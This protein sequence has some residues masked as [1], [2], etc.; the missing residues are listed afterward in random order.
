MLTFDEKLSVITSF[1]ELQRKD[2]SLGRVN[3]QYN[4]SVYDK[5]NVVYHLHPNGNGFVYAGHLSGYDT[6]DKGL[7]NIREFSQEELRT[8]I[9]QSINS[10]SHRPEHEMIEEAVI[11]DGREQ[12]WHGPE[13][14][15]LLLVHE[16]SLW[17]IYAGLNLEAAFESY[18]EAEDYLMDEGFS[19]LRD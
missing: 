18:E 15:T 10:L 8:I 6:N 3:F 4:E 7:V 1:S 16:D 17:N 14:A 12:R 9:E 5:K 11:G 13:G 19:R 2:V